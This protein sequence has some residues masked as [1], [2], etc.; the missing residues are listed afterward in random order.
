MKRR[1]CAGS[2]R[3]SLGGPATL[4]APDWGR[5][6]V[7][8]GGH[9]LLQKGSWGLHLPVLGDPLRPTHPPEVWSALQIVLE[10]QDTKQNAVGRFLESRSVYHHPQH[11][12]NANMCR[13]ERYGKKRSGPF[14]LEV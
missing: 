11:L 1:G 14:Y 9:H 12:V 5:G 3:N 2:L 4:L 13:T 7:A 10:V 6:V 8:A